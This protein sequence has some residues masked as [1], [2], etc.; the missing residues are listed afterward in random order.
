[1]DREREYWW[2][3]APSLT[4]T[5]LVSST[6][7]F[8]RPPS[9]L[10]TPNLATRR[11]T[12]KSTFRHY[13]ISQGYPFE[14]SFCG[15]YKGGRSPHTP[16]FIKVIVLAGRARLQTENTTDYIYKRTGGKW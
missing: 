11:G 1:M 3:G 14:M 4:H 8:G 2:T 10:N 12:R 16:L 6:Y 13:D 5:V 9:I 7:I 15:R